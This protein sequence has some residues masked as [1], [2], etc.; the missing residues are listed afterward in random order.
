MDGASIIII[1]IHSSLPR[2]I[3]TLRVIFER[4]ERCAKLQ[5]GP[6][7]ASPGPML[8]KQV[9]TEVNEV[10]KSRLFRDIIIRDVKKIR[11]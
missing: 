3:S 6:T 2:S 1:G 11:I 7:L 9:V 10:V 4:S 5:V 8:L